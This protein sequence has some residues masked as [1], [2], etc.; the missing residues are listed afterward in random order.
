M[1]SAEPGGDLADR[2]GHVVVCGLGGLGWRIV[3]QLHRRDVPVVVVDD[4]HAAART[5]RTLAAWGVPLLTADASLPG[6]LEAVG[7]AGA[8]AVVCVEGGDAGELRNL[9]IALH[10][11]DRRPDVRVVTALGNAAIGRAVAADPGPGAVLDV[12]ALVTPALVEACLQSPVHALEIGGQ[13]FVAVA[14]TAPAPASLRELYG[15]LAPLAVTGGSPSSTRVCPGRDERVDAGDL[16][17]VLGDDPEIAAAGIDTTAPVP[18]RRRETTRRGGGYDPDAARGSAGPL[19]RALAAVLAVGRESDRG[20]RWAI[21]ALAGLLLLSTAVI[22][23]GYRYPDG[24]RMSLVD[25]LYFT[26]EAVATVGFGDYSFAGQSPWLRVWAIF[27]MLAGV[28]ATA[29]PIAFF[30]DMLISR[31]L[32]ATAGR[33]AASA[34]VGHVVIVGLGAVGVSVMEALVA[35]GRD[36]VVV[37]ADPGNRHLPR[38]RA[39]RVP[40][41]FGDATTPTVLGDARVPRAAAVAVLTSDDMANIET[42]LAVRDLLDPAA[43]APVVLRLFDRELART[44]ARRFGFDTVRSIAELAAPWFVGAA[45]GLD[46][47]GTFP[48]H[49]QAFLLGRLRVERGSALDGLAMRDL[50]ARTRVVALRRVTDPRGRAPL[51]HPPRRD[52]RFTA[53]DEAF[54]VGPDSELLEVLGHSR[55]SGPP[56]GPTQAPAALRPG[57]R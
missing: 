48:V 56:E 30:T 34:S 15:D 51:E 26:V 6:T 29:I 46:V 14:T 50:S 45:L 5:E 55:A 49:G 38:A 9:H 31:R 11:R 12:A 27:L 17:T 8:R 53:G 4:T 41:V 16:V 54:L 1:A 18:G 35:R 33:R 2:R 3:E 25:A 57:T 28:A 21:A 37:E 36:V 22:A 20:L 10:V 24:A 42:G 47:L 40:V 23:V 39:L 19:A 7:L 13:R 52:T 32:S 44:V 43:A